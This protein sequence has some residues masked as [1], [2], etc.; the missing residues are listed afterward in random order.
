MLTAV[1][2]SAWAVIVA[3]AVAAGSVLYA[4]VKGRTADT[5]VARSAQQVAEAQTVAAQAKTETAEVRDAEAQ[6]NATAAQAAEQAVKERTH[7]ENVIS[8][9]PAGG[10]QQRL[11][12]QWSRGDGA[13]RTA[14]SAGQ[15]PDH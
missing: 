13:D 8:A 10:A 14:G 5:K 15:D 4:F 2:S 3:A 12:D 6:A 1:F 11:L 7:V 9:L